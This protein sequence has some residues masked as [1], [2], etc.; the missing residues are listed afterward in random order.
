MLYSLQAFIVYLT[1]RSN[2]A[3]KKI[4]RLFEA[5]VRQPA[6]GD[7][8]DHGALCIG[9]STESLYLEFG[10][11]DLY[12]FGLVSYIAN[13]LFLSLNRSMKDFG[14]KLLV[15]I[16][17]LVDHIYKFHGFGFSWR[18]LFEL[19]PEI[20][21]INKAPE[22]RDVVSSLVNFL[23]SS[24]VDDVV[25]GL[26]DFK[27]RKQVIEE[28]SFLSKVSERE[29]AAFNFTL[30]ESLSL[31][32]HYNRRLR[33]LLAN[34]KADDISRGDSYVHSV[35]FVRMIL[36]D[37]HFYDEEFD[38]AIAHYM[39]AVQSMQAVDP[40]VLNVHRLVVLT[41]NLLKLGL[42]FEKKK[43]FESA[44]VTYGKLV[45]LIVQFRDVDLEQ[46]GLELRS[47]PSGEGSRF[48]NKP[49][50]RRRVSDGN[51]R[52]GSQDF[53]SALAGLDFGSEVESVAFKATAFAAIRLFGAAPGGEAARKIEKLNQG[54]T[55]ERRPG[56]GERRVRLPAAHPRPDSAGDAG[57]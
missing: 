39:E 28:I 50:A 3:P 27:F 49:G 13:P 36:G 38:Q 42:A 23:G 31:K 29:A 24:H 47:E 33:E 11:Y 56:D 25:G 16:S 53:R 6:P 51:L 44:F 22:L 30:D 18:N 15:S 4:T 48:Y 2:G 10:Y 7:L 19:I 55:L 5:F 46:L 32:R 17:F 1:Y 14:D 43:T 40:K 12:T 8:D 54:G 35:G 37:L 52:G 34:Y 26:Y 21:D 9:K 41:R 20:I 57:C 45:S